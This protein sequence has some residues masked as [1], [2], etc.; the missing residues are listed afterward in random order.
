VARYAGLAPGDYR[1]RV[2]AA[3]RDGVWTAF[4]A[5][6]DIRVE[7]PYWATAGFRAAVAAGVAALLAILYRWRV[8]HLIELER[9][10]LRIAGD[11]HDELGSDL[12]GIALASSRL[13]AREA[14]AEA[15]RR[16]LSE[17]EEAALR[18]MRGLR[19]IV[20]YVDPEHDTLES[21]ARRMRSVAS[22]LLSELE[23]RFTTNLG[24][25]TT[26]I[27]MGTRRQLFL[28]FK[29]LTHNVV[30][31][32]RATAAEI[33]L[34]VG[35]GELLLRI[36]DDGVGFDPAVPTDGSGLASVRR[37]VLQ[38]AGQIEIA[39]RPGGGVRVTVQAPM[40]RSR[41]RA[42]GGRGPRLRRGGGAP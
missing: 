36:R 34:E 31:H 15:D 12:S 23:L 33:D 10:R 19:D 30:R 22:S 14:I 18:V 3:N 17:I 8:R 38:I 5:A 16:R 24:E 29:E 1:F 20:W 42:I 4:P 40:T 2:R 11:L 41:Q 27:D 35:R 26:P 39:S 25:G 13:G 37:R 32:A 28:I 6:L 9:M 7:P 21:T